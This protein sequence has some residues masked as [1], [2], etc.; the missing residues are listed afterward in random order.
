MHFTYPLPKPDFLFVVVLNMV[1]LNVIT[2]DK[3]PSPLP[4]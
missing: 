1:V 4:K 2:I 3:V